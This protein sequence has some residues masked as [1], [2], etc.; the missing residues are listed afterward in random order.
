M[1]TAFNKNKE[2]YKRLNAELGLP[3]NNGNGEKIVIGCNYHTTWQTSRAMRFVLDL[4]T[5]SNG[6]ARLI[7][8]NTKKVFW[9]YIDDLIFI[10]TEHNKVKA[11]K[12]CQ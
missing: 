12:L 9:V 2:E 5:F 7:T 6:R 3:K 8:R 10:K 1:N 4:V 11:R